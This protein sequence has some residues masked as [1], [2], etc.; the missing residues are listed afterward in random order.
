MNTDWQQKLKDNPIPWLLES[1]PWTRYRTL[2][3][4]LEV[5]ISS[6]EVKQV[7][8]E[9]CTH[10]QVQSLVK[11]TTRWFPQSITRHNDSK[12]SHYGFMTLTELGMTKGDP[13][14]DNIINRASEHLDDRD[15]TDI[16]SGSAFRVARTT[17]YVSHV[18]PSTSH[19]RIRV[20]ERR[21][22]SRLRHH[23]A[24]P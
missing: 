15:T 12:I 19:V 21:R 24:G 7:K 22:H 17:F 13:G 2:T 1:N 6:P 11:E 5:P 16:A 3:D 10:P 23:L 14:I 18:A 20:A 4:L 9:L 8:S